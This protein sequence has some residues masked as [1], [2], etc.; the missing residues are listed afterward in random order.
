[1]V[2]SNWYSNQTYKRAD[3]VFVEQ[4]GEYYVCVTDHMS[5]DLGMPSREDEKWILIDASFIQMFSNFSFGSILFMPSNVQETV[6]APDISS[7][8]QAEP[9]QQQTK[10]QKT[11]KRKLEHAETSVREYK[12]KKN[13]LDVDQLRDKLMLLKVDVPTKAYL[14][15]KYEGTSRMSGSDYSKALNW[16]NTVVSIPFGTYKKMTPEDRNTKDFFQKVKSKLDASIYG[17]E[18]VKQEILEYVARKVTNPNGKGHVL[19][20]CGAP[21]T[22]KTKLIKSLASALDLPFFQINCGGLNDASILNGHSETYVGAKPGKL[23]DLLT[24]SEYMNPIIYLDEIDKIS[25]NKSRE[26]N[27]VLTH[28]LDEEQNDKFQDNYL[29]NVNIN[30][31]KAFF[32]ITFN[33][34]LQVD[35]IVSDRM[36][37]I[38]IKPP[39]LDEKVRICQDKLIPDIIASMNFKHTTCINI[40]KETI[41][42]LI[43][44][45]CDEESGVRQLKKSV[46]K[47]LSR[48]NYDIL[49]EDDE[50]NIQLIKQ[51]NT[52]TEDYTVTRGYVDKVLTTNKTNDMSYLNMYL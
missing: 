10:Q 43:T 28:L 44:K 42:Y 22:G 33:D 51:D 18:D 15:D 52:V 29:S 21:G 32:V 38:Y 16:L 8:Y 1:M 49:I 2:F 30:L 37:V 19:A 6:S 45:K 17:M 36:H 47:I 4:T 20:L 12:R 9:P 35:E 26:I 23:V 24:K 41:E 31:S 46:E 7:A 14:L 25:E 40:S 34:P 3:I 39:T 5:Y 27:G 48:L 11:L 50:L 13:K